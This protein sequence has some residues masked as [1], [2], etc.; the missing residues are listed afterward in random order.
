MAEY[1]CDFY[2]LIYKAQIP[3]KFGCMDDGPEYYAGL[4]IL[5]KILYKIRPY[6]FRQRQKK[7]KGTQ[8]VPISKQRKPRHDYHFNPINTR[9]YYTLISDSLMRISIKN[10]HIGNHDSGMF[11]EMYRDGSAISSHYIDKKSVNSWMHGDIF[12]YL[13]TFDFCYFPGINQMGMPSEIKRTLDVRNA[14]GSSELSETLSMYYMYLKFKASNFIPEMEVDYQIQSHI[15]DYLM[16]INETKIGVSVTRA[17]C[18]PFGENIPYDFATSLL[19]KKL[20]GIITAKKSVSRSHQFDTSVIHVWCNSWITAQII[21]E[22]FT[23]II[24]DDLY[25]LFE[26][27]YIV[28]SVCHANFIYTNTVLREL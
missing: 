19:Y 27:I 13:F 14:G 16:N 22:A 6:M 8:I 3:E 7:S 23:M 1:I 4:T 25:G 10:D 5:G 26:N 9:L 17:L 12:T 21:R 15:C 24:K 2:W 11:T 28:C 20:I 18:Y